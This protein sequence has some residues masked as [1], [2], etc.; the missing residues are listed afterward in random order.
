MRPTAI[1]ETLARLR[2]NNEMDADDKARIKL[3][4]DSGLNMIKAPKTRIQAAGV[5]LVGA[6][7]W[8]GDRFASSMVG[9]AAAKALTA[10]LVVL[11]L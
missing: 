9:I 3:E 6:L 8:L 1:E 7:K 4:L 2:E 11:G 5:V 10:I